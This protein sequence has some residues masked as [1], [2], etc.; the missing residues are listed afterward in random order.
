MGELGG[1]VS[2]L[3]W[4][5][6]RVEAILTDNGIQVPESSSKITSPGIYGL[7]PTYERSVSGR[8]PQRA[9]IADLIE[10]SLGQSVI[11]RFDGDPGPRYAKGVGTL[12]F[13][14]F[15]NDFEY[16]RESAKHRA[17][18]FTSCNYDDSDR[19]PSRSAFSVAWRTLQAT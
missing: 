19:V 3:Y 13:G 8:R 17:L 14:Q 18:I 7:A 10:H 9:D 6:R 5:E 11:S 16:P 15:I 1:V 12:V 2:Y 4:S